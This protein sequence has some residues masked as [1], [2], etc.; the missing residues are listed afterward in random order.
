MQ[1]GMREYSPARARHG[2]TNGRLKAES[3]RSPR[4]DMRIRCEELQRKFGD[5]PQASPDHTMSRWLIL[6]MSGMGGVEFSVVLPSMW[7]YVQAI[8]PEPIAYGWPDEKGYFRLCLLYTSPSP[9][10]S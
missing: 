8:A 9:R 3:P 6:I 1:A 7:D 5:V 2:V 10:D 4:D